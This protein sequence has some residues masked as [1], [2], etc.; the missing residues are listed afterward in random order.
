MQRTIF[1]QPPLQMGVML[2]VMEDIHRTKIKKLKSSGTCL[3]AFNRVE[4]Q[5]IIAQ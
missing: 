1:R 2:L 3:S 4:K 5:K